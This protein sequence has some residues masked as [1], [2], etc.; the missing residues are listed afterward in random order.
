MAILATNEEA[1]INL[2][3]ENNTNETY[4]ISDENDY[5][6]DTTTSTAVEESGTAEI[7]TTDQA[8]ILKES[9]NI[10]GKPAETSENTSAIKDITTSPVDDI[11]TTT[12]EE[13]TT[14]DDNST[15]TVSTNDN[16]D[17]ERND[18]NKSLAF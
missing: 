8:I 11:T 18:L 9:S 4:D 3:S 12:V 17:D 14:F 13:T 7:A 6:T 1:N 5:S 16:G 15:T 10:T 2:A